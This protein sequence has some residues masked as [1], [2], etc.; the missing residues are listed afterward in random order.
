NGTTGD[1]FLFVNNK[2]YTIKLVNSTGQYNLTGLSG[3]N[4][5]VFAFYNGDMLFDSSYNQTSFSV[6]KYD[7]PI[8]ITVK[9]IYVGQIATIKVDFPTDINGRIYVYIDDK[10]YVYY[11]RTSLTIYESDLP[12]GNVTVRVYHDGNEKY[13]DNNTVAYF[14]VTKKNMTITIQTADIVVGENATISVIIPADAK[15]IVLLNVNGTRY[16]E[17]ANG[18]VAK[19]IISGLAKGSYNVTTAYYEGPVYN[20]AN[21]TS[22][23]NV[24]YVRAYDFNVSASVDN[25]LNVLV[26]ISLPKDIDGDVYV[27]ING[28]NYTASM[29]K[30]KDIVIIPGLLSGEYNGTVYLVNDSKYAD[31][32]KAFIVDLERVTPT[33]NVE[34]NHT[35]YV[36]DD[37]IIKVTIDGDATGNITISLNNN[38]Y[39]EKIENGV[40]TF[41]ITGLAWNT[42]QFNV[43]FVG[44]RKYLPGQKEHTLEVSRIHNYY[45]NLEIH[46]IFVGENATITV[47]FENDTTGTVTLIINGSTHTITLK[48]GTGSINI[49]GLPVGKHVI[50]ATYNGDRKYEPCNRIFEDFHVKKL[51]DYDFVPSGK[52]N[53]THANI[54]VTLPTDANGHVNI[55]VNGQTYKNIEV[56][57]GKANLTVGGLTSGTEY[58][59]KID[60][61]GNDKYE[62]ASKT[63]TL[64]SEKT[65]NYN[66]T[67]QG[68][69]IH[70]GD[71]A[72]I[73]IKLPEANDT[74]YVVVRV[75]NITNPYN[76]FVVNGTVNL[77]VNNN[78][79]EGEYYVTVEYKG[80]DQFESSTKSTYIYVSKIS[81]FRFDVVT[82]KPQ[83]GENLTVD[84]RLPDDTTGNVTVTV[85]I[86]NTN[87]TANVTNGTAHVDIPNLPVGVYNT[88]VYYSGDDKY[89]SAVKTVE[90]I[91]EKIDEYEF[92]VV[93]VDIYVGQ[94]ETIKI[95]LPKDID[96]NVTIRIYNTSYVNQ[97]I[98][99]VN[100]TGWFNVTGLAQGQ[101]V[102]YVT[103]HN[104]TKYED[105]TVFANFKVSLITDY[106]FDVN[107]TNPNYVR[108]NITFSVKL[109]ENATGNVTV[110]IFGRDYQGVIKNGNAT[111]NITAPYYGTFP[112][113]VS[114]EQEGKYSL[115]SQT[116]SVFISKINVDLN[117]EYKSPVHVGEN[118]TFKVKLP[119]D[120]TGT[121]TVITRMVTYT[122]TLIN[123]SASITVPGYP[124]AQ[125]YSPSISYS[126]DDRYN[127]N[128]TPI[129]LV[130]NKVSD[131]NLTVNVSDIYVGQTEAVNITLPADATDDVLIYGN[132][133]QRRYSQ[134]I[135]NGNV[136]FNIADLPAGTYNITVLYQGY[137]KYESKNVT[138]TF[139][140]RK[141]NST[142]DIELVNRTIIVTVPDDAT[143]NV[144]I[145]ISDIKQNVTI[146]NGKATLDVSNL[147]PDD[148]KVNASFAGD[149]RY[150]A[151]ATNKTVTIPQFTDYSIIVTAGNIIV[152][153]NATIIVKLPGDANGYANITVNTTVFRNVEVKDGNA[154]LNVNTTVV[155]AV[156]TYSVTVSFTDKKYALN[157]NSTTFKVEKIK[158]ILNPSI[159][160]D[161]RNIT[162]VVGINENATGNITIYVDNVP[163]SREIKGNKATLTLTKLMP[164]DH[165]VQSSYAGDTNH[166]DART[167]LSVV[168]IDKISGYDL[169]ID[170][171]EIITVDEN[172]NIT[173]IFPEEA[174]GRVTINY[175]DEFINAE[176]NTTT[177]SVTVQL[178]LLKSGNYTV[179]VDYVDKLYDYVI[180][181]TNFTVIKLNTTLDVKVNNITKD[182]SEIINISLS[183]NATGDVLINVNGTVYH[184]ELYLGTAS[185]TLTNLEEGIYNVTVIY[186]GDDRL[187]G[188][189]TSVNFTVSR[190]PLDITINA[191]D[192]IVGHVLNIKFNM[193]REITD[194]VTVQVGK[195]NYTTFAYKGNGSLD[196]YDLPVGD[197]NIT[198]YYGGSEDYLPT[199]NKTNITV[200]GKKSS[201]LN[202]NVEDI[203][204]GE[205]ITVYVN[206]TK[207]I[208]GPVYV[209]IAG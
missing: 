165:L 182:L 161:G 40:A 55:T 154:K 168:P 79:K 12:A 142:I 71:V 6:Y 43:T 118:V 159:S 208:N 15:G 58:P 27:E 197:Y 99:V 89:H 122:V 204:V 103:L 19:F 162:V 28:T 149:E 30:G 173:V 127:A 185:L 119:E 117:P 39:T 206:A 29:S 186:D 109:P 136:A 7:N 141:N 133:S 192:I 137:D 96:G 49:T 24:N 113:R 91:V 21:A 177:H 80:N 202:V 52:T 209:T 207:G 17:Y 94:N 101:Y 47:T 102:A 51:I 112:Y 199:S 184:T 135:T 3:G 106:L 26:D 72:N 1:V 140:V 64:N 85:S 156:G 144:T 31:S 134:A 38:N 53:D 87:Y 157:S 193:S 175:N 107:V 35:I 42:Y 191:S 126:G 111:V 56:K 146:V 187:Y 36:D 181:S 10:E 163:Y 2:I 105:D 4:Y 166:S 45:S 11:N 16:F 9:D 13:Y 196:V 8:N 74:D 110:T 63:I 41:N 170:L 172:N 78:F 92:S 57:D 198:I 44:D 68:D 37:A 95:V 143:G 82:N 62:S 88:T 90:V 164:G 81:S 128:S 129:N 123:G 125:S 152:G 189:V 171:T 75:Q 179:S 203:T 201:S 176:I 151:N 46:D 83:V 93:P 34:Y 195:T 100:G 104:D 130:V 5:T 183:N 67:V 33:I 50:N 174:Y 73:I 115:K 77:T 48:N 148:Y 145:S 108:N 61:S 138:K 188:N 139:T 25:D 98:N 150:F 153:Q 180:N 160:V 65:L 178:P 14:N 205:N 60:Y 120:A 23:F 131:Y 54:T 22:S 167:S 169:I 32:K 155:G 66:F 84:I 97:V 18:T 114:F 190:I 20:Y 116:G 158:T 69:S 86:N 59:V 76:L 132:F 200:N 70:V 194:L 147:Y 121:I 124:L